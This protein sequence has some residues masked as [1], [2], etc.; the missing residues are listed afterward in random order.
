MA[1][2]QRSKR[3]GDRL[4]GAL[5]RASAHGARSAVASM[6]SMWIGDRRL[7]PLGSLWSG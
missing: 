1:A 6:A 2:C 3:V 5:V 4:P 7:T